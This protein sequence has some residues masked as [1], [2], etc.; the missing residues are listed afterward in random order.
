M[1][2]PVNHDLLTTST[3]AT[4]TSTAD[5]APVELPGRR[6]V[7]R[8]TVPHLFE[9]GIH[10][11]HVEAFRE[12]V[13]EVLRDELVPL[14]AKAEA[15]RRFPRAAIEAVGRAGLIRARWEGGGH[16]DLGRAVI[17]GE[18]AGY[19]AL[20]GVGVGIS[21]HMEAVTATLTR[22]A[23]TAPVRAARDGA[24]DGTLVGC[25]ATTERD[26]GSDL[27]SMASTMTPV[28]EGQ[29]RVQGRKWF[30]SPG[31]AA[32]FGLILCRTDD[33][34]AERTGVI[35]PLGLVMVPREGLHI[36]KTVPTVG[37]RGLGTARVTVDAVVDND[38]VVGKPGT[39]LL[40]ASWGLT[41]E[42]LG[43]AAGVIGMA[44]L[45]I[46]LA[47]TRVK[48]RQQFGVR[49]FDHQAL[50]LRLA[51]L[52]A[53]VE[54]A[55][56]GLYAL[57]AQLP[58]LPEHGLR[59]TAAMKVTSVRMAHHVIDECMHCFGGTGYVEGETP[60]ERIWRDVRVGR[61]GAGSDE[62]MWELVAGGLRG[63]DE[64]YDRLMELDR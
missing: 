34:R 9:A 54:V 2:V 31:A 50:R 53:Q 37:M 6:F 41:H 1:S 61:L 60:F 17:L 33:A 24:L 4:S 3:L 35:A 13:R 59:E 11:P 26:T 23:R 5:A 30:L 47:T 7:R 62:M 38:N 63:D 58:S 42:R 48:R 32:D 14:V 49:L 44:R 46:A 27:T 52:H 10:G 18:E 51:D 45:A 64:A 16:G 40:L 12:E 43:I 55:R 57:A 56:N 22:F 20:G 8:P 36:E 29:W 25:M 19:A 28:G 21:L 15:E 39:A